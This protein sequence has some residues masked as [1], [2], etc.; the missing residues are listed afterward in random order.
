MV[1][2]L[3]GAMVLSV[4]LFGFARWVGG[5]GT[6]YTVQRVSAGVRNL[7]HTG[8]RVFTRAGAKTN[9]IRAE[10]GRKGKVELRLRSASV[11]IDTATTFKSSSGCA[12]A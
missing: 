2:G 7:R 11:H 1:H 4:F 3:H 5:A 6:D 9:D 8:Q 12:D 10:M